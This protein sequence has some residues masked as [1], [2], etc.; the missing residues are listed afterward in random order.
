MRIIRWLD[1]NLE[2]ALM[3]V[4]MIVL[5]FVMGAQVVAR[6]FLGA[7]IDWSEELGRYLFV[8]MGFLQLQRGIRLPPPG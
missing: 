3:V 8:W 6:K 7:S 2:V 5:I 4:A 1:R